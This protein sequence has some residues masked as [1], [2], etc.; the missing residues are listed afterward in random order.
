MGFCQGGMLRV[1]VL[2]ALITCK[3]TVSQVRQNATKLA[4][5]YCYAEDC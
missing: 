3:S 5:I 4:H 2:R 1:S